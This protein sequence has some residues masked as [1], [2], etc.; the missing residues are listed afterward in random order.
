MSCSS[1]WD[2][3]CHI[4]HFTV[5]SALIFA[6]RKGVI[7][8]SVDG[9][10]CWKDRGAQ[11]MAFAFHFVCGTLLVTTTKIDDLHMAG[12]YLMILLNCS[13]LFLKP[14]VED[15]FHNAIEC[16]HVLQGIVNPRSCWNVLIACLLT[17]FCWY[18]LCQAMFLI[19]TVFSSL[20]YAKDSG[21]NQPF[22]ESFQQVLATEQ[23]LQE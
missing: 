5:I 11:S 9:A 10:R 19:P 18:L 4:V 14:R 15:K 7:V 20:C 16:M 17:S 22:P 2:K 8:G 23:S 21:L 13:Y 3:C 12:C 6:M 1:V